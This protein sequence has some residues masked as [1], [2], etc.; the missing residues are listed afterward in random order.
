MSQI[1][2]PLGYVKPLTVEGKVFLQELWTRKAGL[3]EVL[4]EKESK[5]WKEFKIG[6]DGF[7]NISFGRIVGTQI[8]QLFFFC[9]ASVKAYA[10][11]VDVKS[12][13][14]T[15]LIFSKNRI[16]PL[17]INSIPRMELLVVLIGVRSLEIHRKT[18]KSFP[19]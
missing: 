8:Q 16:A 11:T 12:N 2:D 19:R 18:I 17:K 7:S 14:G 9:D 13:T 3:D 5:R 4:T 10:T 6:M 1:Y 15:H